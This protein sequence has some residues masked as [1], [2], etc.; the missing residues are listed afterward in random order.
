M[1]I[2]ILCDKPSAQMP[3]PLRQLKKLALFA[4]SGT[5]CKCCIGYRILFAAAVGIIIGS[6][7]GRLL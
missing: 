5:D 7:I 2:P 3:T 6:V 4:A 1:A